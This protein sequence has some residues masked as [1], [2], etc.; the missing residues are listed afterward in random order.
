MQQMRKLKPRQNK[1]YAG[2]YLTAK[3]KILEAPCSGPPFI[4]SGL[5]SRLSLEQASVGL[6]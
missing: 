4:S 6:L 3:W 1:Q 2:N 5:P